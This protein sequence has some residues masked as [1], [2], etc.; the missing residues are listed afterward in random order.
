MGH[1]DSALDEDASSG[2]DEKWSDLL[3]QAIFKPSFSVL[4]ARRGQCGTSALGRL[5]L[6]FK[7]FDAV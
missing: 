4:R 5:G 6:G 2:G 7:F 3:M 1:G